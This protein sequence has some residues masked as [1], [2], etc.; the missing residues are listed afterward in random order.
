LSKKAN[1]ALIG[2][3]VTGAVIL[4]IGALIFFGSGILFSERQTFVLFFNSSLKGLEKG[5]P[6]TFRGVPIGQV[7]KISILIDPET[8]NFKMPVY[9]SIDPKSMFSYSGA[10]RVSEVSVRKMTELLINKGLKAQLQI[11]SL[12]TGKLQVDLDFYPEAPVHYVGLDKEHIEIPTVPSTVEEVIRRFE[13]IPLDDL[14]EK[15][16]SAIDGLDKLVKSG[17]IGATIDILHQN[18]VDI[19]KNMAILMPELLSTLQSIKKTS[20]STNIFMANADKKLLEISRQISHLAKSA[21]Q[22]TVKLKKALTNLER[23]SSPNSYE[24]YQL[25]RLLEESARA[26]RA[27]RELA[28]SIEAQPDILIKGRSSSEGD[29]DDPE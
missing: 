8:G 13:E 20:G 6:V 27:I 29:S 11:Q 12:V 5:S 28:E 22:V 21:S 2:A 17:K 14:V 9:I 18:L 16:I 23:M 19:K 15:L 10:G 1:P 25:K 4:L 24:R 7:K 3:F 26:A